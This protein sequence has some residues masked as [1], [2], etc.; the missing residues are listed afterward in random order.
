[1]A[2]AGVPMVVTYRLHPLSAALLRRM[3]CVPYASLVNLLLDAPALPELI[4][5]N[6]R[7]DMLAGALHLLLTDEEARRRQRVALHAALMQLGLGQSPSPSDRAAAVVLDTV[8][9]RP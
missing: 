1:M 5:E 2:M 8:K 7:A 3:V 6:C 4:Q 9:L